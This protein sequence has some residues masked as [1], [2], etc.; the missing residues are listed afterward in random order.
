MPRYRR[1]YRAIAA[2]NFGATGIIG[3][4]DINKFRPMNGWNGRIG[5]HRFDRLWTHSV[6]K[7]SEAATRN[8]QLASRSRVKAQALKR[9]DELGQPAVHSK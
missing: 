5:S 8:L 4:A 7:S 6:N 3:V 9:D 1:E 2:V